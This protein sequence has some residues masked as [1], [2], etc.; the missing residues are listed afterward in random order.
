M[1][2][3]C[4]PPHPCP[5][6]TPSP[7]AAVCSWYAAHYLHLPLQLDLVPSA[8]P[9][10]PVLHGAHRTLLPTARMRTVAAAAAAVVPQWAVD[11]ALRH[12]H[13][14]ASLGR[15]AAA[16]AAAA[17]GGGHGPL[18]QLG[19]DAV[20]LRLLPPPRP[21]SDR[22]VS[23]PAPLLT[24]PRGF[25]GPGAA[26]VMMP[27]AED[28][29]RARGSRHL[30]P[31]TPDDALLAGLAECLELAL[32]SCSGL[33]ERFH[34]SLFLYALTGPDSYVS[35]E[36]YIC[37]VVLLIAA[38]ALRGAALLGGGTGGAAGGAAGGG[39]GDGTTSRTVQ[40]SVVQGISGSGRPSCTASAALCVPL[41]NSKGASGGRRPWTDSKGASGRRQ[42]WTDAL[43]RVASVH[44]M[45]A[46]TGTLVRTAPA[47][48]AA[49][50]RWTAAWDGGDWRWCSTGAA[51]PTLCALFAAAALA[52]VLGVSPGSC[53]S[54]WLQHTTSTSHASKHASTAT[55]AHMCSTAASALGVELCIAAAALAGEACLN[56]AAAYAAALLLSL[57]ALCVAPLADG[58]GAVGTCCRSMAA[59]AA[60]VA[61]S[62]C[63]VAAMLAMASS[64]GFMSLTSRAWLEALA[65]GSSPQ[66]Y[67]LAWGV[68]LPAWVLSAWSAA[69]LMLYVDM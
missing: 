63:G 57:L 67:A 53:M 37:P 68:W 54:S 52:E 11:A 20:T 65:W 62:P 30:P 36:R 27:S 43:R 23:T 32:R 1:H 18:K 42:P 4:A 60:I 19:T 46:V 51:A 31:P 6:C 22:D 40:Q 8:Q 17:P 69:V 66:L 2:T 38:L 45:C 35:V 55:A 3:L 14:L 16:Q 10:T 26:R 21:V 28:H 56:W 33:V 49:A 34:H 44:A 5:P 48:S 47:M 59:V 7:L 39:A 25:V 50:A 24:P 13:A 41:S 64:R 61:A 15:F 29:V 9:I 58:K 12:A